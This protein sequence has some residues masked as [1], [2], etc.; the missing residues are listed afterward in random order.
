VPQ[1]LALLGKTEAG[2]ASLA[3]AVAEKNNS[4]WTGL[5]TVAR[6][7]PAAVP[8][9]L[10]L[11]GETEAGVAS[12]VRAVAEKDDRQ[13]TGL[14]MVARH[15]PDA[16]PQLLTLLGETEGGREALVRALAEKNNEQFTGLQMV[17]FSAP[18]ALPRL[19][20]ISVKHHHSNLYA[21]LRPR[22]TLSTA[23]LKEHE[24]SMDDVI[25]LATL[26]LG[27]PINRVTQAELCALTTVIDD[28]TAASAEEVRVALGSS[29]TKLSKIVAHEVGGGSMPFLYRIF[30]TPIS[31]RR[32]Q[33]KMV[34][35]LK[36]FG[37]PIFAVERNSLE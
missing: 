5:Q 12:L 2:V 22:V 17:A 33:G 7:A 3:R 28:L 35:H 15:V 25:T 16:V 9:L 29:I 19:L 37:S 36:N 23:Y 21:L 20:I 26:M 11:L 6:H 32:F 10:T 27:D 14:H 34:E 4:Q 18:A 1:L 8:Q 13:W 30:A 24:Y 31:K